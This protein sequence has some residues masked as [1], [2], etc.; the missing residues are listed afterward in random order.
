MLLFKMSQKK[1]LAWAYGIL[2]QKASY[3][4]IQRCKSMSEGPEQCEGS[5]QRVFA[6]KNEFKT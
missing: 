1:N 5:D 6:E 2:S 4:W 3:W